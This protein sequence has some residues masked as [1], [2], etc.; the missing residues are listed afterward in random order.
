MKLGDVW[1]EEFKRAR[2]EIRRALLLKTRV[3]C[4]T[5]PCRVDMYLPKFMRG[6]L[7]AI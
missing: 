3:F 6:F 7:T 5:T 2:F 1:R 4:V